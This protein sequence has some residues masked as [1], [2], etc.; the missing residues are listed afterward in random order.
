MNGNL[1]L[2]LSLFGLAMGLATVFIIPSTIEP[3]FWLAI[4]VVCAAIIARKAPG[5]YFFHGFLVS[6]L[7]SVWIT[8]A[9][10]ILFDSYVARHA[11]E[12][13]MMASMPM[14]DSPRL[15]MLATGPV[16]GAVSGL[17][18]GLFSFVASKLVKRKQ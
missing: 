15:M 3:L 14:A 9:H 16:I 17:V 4:F 6:M 18:L 11:K 2:R 10:V 7:N 12:V 8:A 13:A 5:K 1:I